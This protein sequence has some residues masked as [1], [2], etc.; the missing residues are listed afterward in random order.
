[1]WSPTTSSSTA[2]SS[3]NKQNIKKE[4]VEAVEVD[5]CKCSGGE[6]Q[7]KNNSKY[8]QQTSTFGAQ[9]TDSTEQKK[10]EIDLPGETS[11]SGFISGPQTTSSINI[12]FEEQ[13]QQQAEVIGSVS[14]SGVGDIKKLNIPGSF[15]EPQLQKHHHHHQQH[16]KYQEKQQQQHNIDSGYLDVDSEQLQPKSQQQFDTDSGCI[17]EVGDMKF[18]HNVDAGLPEWFCNLSLQNSSN[19]ANNNNLSRTNA[20]NSAAG[21][22]NLG[23]SRP[24]QQQRLTQQKSFSSPSSYA[25]GQQTATVPTQITPANAWEKFYQQNDD[26][27]T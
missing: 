5:D 11:D 10:E 1:M 6:Q 4:E 17:E 23:A 27:D 25:A 18:K 26:G 20:S 13:Q 15:S 8:P 22:N 21:L 2:S 16:F 9:F 14:V 24:Q 12:D 7:Q 3:D 19:N